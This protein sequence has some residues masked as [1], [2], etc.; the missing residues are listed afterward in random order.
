MGKNTMM[1]RIKKT[2]NQIIYNYMCKSI[3]KTPPLSIKPAPLIICSMI[4]RKDVLMYLVA[5]KSLYR[6]IGEGYIRVI[7]DGTLDQRS[8]DFLKFHLGE[9]DIVNISDVP[10]G[11]C[12]SGGTWE[13]LLHIIDLSQHSYVIQI[14]SDVVVTG[15]I[16]EVVA[17]YKTNKSFIMSGSRTDQVFTTL[18]ETTKKAKLLPLTHVQIAAEQ[19]LDMLPNAYK[20]RYVRGCSGFAGFAKNAISRA[21]AEEFSISMEKILQE[22]W[23]SWGSEQVTSNYLIAN[24]S[25]SRI[26]PSSKYFSFYPPFKIEGASLVH[27]I[28]QNRFKHGIYTQESRRFIGGLDT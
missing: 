12:P 16:P 8:I 13:R 5:I 3:L 10:T 25:E 18:D 4:C 23:R 1:H 22:M 2:I 7:N 6:Q 9:L 26:L 15:A 11:V 14:D 19:S 21:Q 17:L 20:R 24:M 27:F 28:G